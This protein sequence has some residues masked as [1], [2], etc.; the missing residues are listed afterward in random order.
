M[1]SGGMERDQRHEI[2]LRND[3]HWNILEKAI[4]PIQTQITSERNIRKSNTKSDFHQQ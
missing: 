2:N 4:K 3:L 1:F